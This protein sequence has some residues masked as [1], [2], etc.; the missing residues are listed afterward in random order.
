MKT[1]AILVLLAAVP[2]ACFNPTLLRGS[3]MASGSSAA[4]ARTAASCTFSPVVGISMQFAD[5]DGP[6]TIPDSFDP[7]KWG[8]NG[9]DGGLGGGGFRVPGQLAKPPPPNIGPDYQCN[10]RVLCNND[11]LDKLSSAQG[12]AG[13][14]CASRHGACAEQHEARAGRGGGREGGSLA[15]FARPP[16]IRRTR[17]LCRFAF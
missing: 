12:R 9:G 16:L 13:C 5:P 10:C 7:S 4:S 2:A 8:K 11:H 6:V 14:N 17:T 1:A 3:S 15:F